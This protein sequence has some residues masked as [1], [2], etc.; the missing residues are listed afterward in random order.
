M[1]PRNVIDALLKGLS[2][3]LMLQL[4]VGPVCLYVLNVA[5]QS[6]LVIG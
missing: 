1:N 2:F 4:A 5:N 6:G 3:G